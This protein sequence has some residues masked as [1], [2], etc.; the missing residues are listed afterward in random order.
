MRDDPKFAQQVGRIYQLGPRATYEILIEI[1]TS[2]SCATVVVDAV[3]KYSELNPDLLKALGAD[4]IPS[5]PLT[6][7]GGD[8]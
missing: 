1:G 3:A 2:A 8:E 7:V 4:K 5:A 6:V